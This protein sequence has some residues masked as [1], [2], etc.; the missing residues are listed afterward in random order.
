[1]LK[2]SLGEELCYYCMET[3]EAEGTRE[4]GIET[5]RHAKDVLKGKTRKA[6]SV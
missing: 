5:G 2:V 4:G 6:T 1:M 3:N